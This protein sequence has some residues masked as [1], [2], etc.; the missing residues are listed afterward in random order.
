MLLTEH[1]SSIV[2]SMSRAIVLPRCRFCG[3][4]WKP[5]RGTAIGSYCM[6]CSAERQSVAKHTLGLHPLTK[7]E[8][9]GRYVLPR[10]RSVPSR[11]AAK[12]RF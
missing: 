12:K 2:A 5:T 1:K 9:A 3:H 11:A 6:R 7:E 4:A 8:T 10:S